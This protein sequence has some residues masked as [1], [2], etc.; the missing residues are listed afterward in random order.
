MPREFW[1]NLAVARARARTFASEPDALKTF[2]DR[3]VAR[4]PAHLETF[5]GW[6]V[7]LLC[8][9]PLVDCYDG[10]IFRNYLDIS[11]SA[12]ELYRRAEIP[13]ETVSFRAHVNA[14]DVGNFRRARKQRIIEST[15]EDNQ[16]LCDARIYLTKSS[17]LSLSLHPWYILQSLPKLTEGTDGIAVAHA[18][19]DFDRHCVELS[20]NRAPRVFATK[21]ERGLKTILI[22]R[23]LRKQTV[24]VQLSRVIVS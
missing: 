3:K 9:E 21:A 12:L 7:E 1:N 17:D 16:M 13:R 2:Q 11:I 18:I 20:L 23:S 10:Y 5:C 24:H 8:P 4:G 15:T 22:R 6:K 14:N 19:C